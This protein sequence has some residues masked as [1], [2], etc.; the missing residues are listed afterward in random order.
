MS[1]LYDRHEYIRDLTGAG[2]N[3]DLAEAIALGA[4]GCRRTHSP[5]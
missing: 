4:Y 5:S 1:V 3:E 2:A